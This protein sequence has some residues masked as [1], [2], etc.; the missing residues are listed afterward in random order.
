MEQITISIDIHATLM[1]TTILLYTLYP[2]LKTKNK[3]ETKN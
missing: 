3:A 1:N 2:T